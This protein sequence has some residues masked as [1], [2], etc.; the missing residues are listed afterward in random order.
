LPTPRKTCFNRVRRVAAPPPLG[1]PSFEPRRSDLI[2]EPGLNSDPIVGLAERGSALVLSLAGELDLYTAPALREALQGAV[3]RSPERLVVDLAGVTF[4]DS[5]ALGAL[6]EAR[7]KL[8][9]GDA[10]ALAAPGLEVRRALEVTGLDRHFAVHERL[11]T[12]I[13]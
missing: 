1:A 2:A 3:A 10:F 12:A 4:I 6:V 13:D 7:S 8:R 5:T 9:D 11:D